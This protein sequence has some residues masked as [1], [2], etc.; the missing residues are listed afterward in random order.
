MRKLYALLATL[1]FSISLYAQVNV[2]ASAG[3]TGPTPY[4]TLKLA[5]D[6]INAGTHQGA[7]TI[8]LSGNTTETASA[9]LNASISPS[10]YS[11]VF[12]SATTPVVISGNITGAVIKLNGADNVTLDGRIGGSGRNITV[13]NTSTSTAT[14]AIWL[15]SVIAGNGA[16]NNI[17]RNLEISAGVDQS[18]SAT[19]TFGIIMSG[20]TISI[21]SNGTDNDN[22]QFVANQIL[23]ARYG[24]LTRGTTTNLNE[25]IIV[26]D[27][28]IGPTAFGSNSI[29]KVGIFMQA[30]AGA[31]VTRNF[32]Q[33]VGGT[34]ATTS[35]GADR[36]GIAIG[37]ENWSNS[38]S[39][40]TSNTYTVTQNIVHDIV[41]ERA[42]SAI[43][44][45]LGTT[46]GG[47][48]TDN[49]VANNFIYNILAN[50]TSGDQAVG[51]GIS[52]GKN[53][54]VVF[55]SIYLSGDLDPG[56]TTSA[57]TSASGIR[58][59]AASSTSFLDLIVKNNNI[60]V[61]LN[62]NNTIQ[63]FTIS[64]NSSTFN[65]GTG[66]LD[67]NNYY[68]PTTNPQ[69]ATGG[70]GN[71]I[72]TTTPWTGF[73]TLT[74]W[75]TAFTPAQDANSIQVVSPFVSATDLHLVAGSSTKL[76]SA[77]IAIA[78]ISTDIDNDTRPGPAGSVNGG[79]TAPDIGADEF[80]GA[81][82][83]AIDLA[84]S[85]LVSPAFNTCET[86]PATVVVRIK[87]EGSST[88]DFST[89]NATVTANVT[90]ATTATVSAILNSGT[91]APGAI[92][93]VPLSPGL[94]MS[95]PG[96]Y[97]FE[98]STTLSGDGNTANNTLNTTSS[99][100][101]PVTLP[102]QVDFTGYTGSNLT[103]VFPNWYEARGANTPVAGTSNWINSSLV[104]GAGTTAKINLAF[105]SDR[106]WIVGP[107]IP[108]IATTILKFDVAI[109]DANLAAADPDG[110]TGTDDSVIVRI[111]TNCGATWTD[112]YVFDDAST[113][114][115]ISNSLVTQTIN[116]SAYAGQ[117]VILAFYATEGTV[118]NLQ[119]YDFHIDNINI[120][121]PTSL[122]VGAI[123]MTTP[124]V[125]PICYGSTE[126]VTITI[127]NYGTSV[128][129]FAA[130]PV[131]V[132]TNVTGAATTSLTGTI[133]AGTLA[134][135]ATT[136]VVMSTTLDMTASGTYTFNAYTN[137][138]GD[139]A[140][141]ND[142]M[143]TV[144]RFNAATVSIP[145][146]VNFTGFTG[147][148][149]A[150]AFPNWREG[151]GSLIPAGTI[152]TWT[153]STVFAAAGTT[154]KILLSSTTDREWI[155]GPKIL[156]ASN[157]NL[158]FKVAITESSSLAVDP[159]GMTG[160]DDS[161]VVRISTDCGI[162]WSNL[163]L[164]TD[165][166]TTGIVSN[167]LV[168]YTIPLGSY[169][170][171]TIMIAFYASE[172]T[173]DDA[174]SYDFHLDDINIYNATA[175]DVGA[176]VLA[177]PL[178]S[179]ACYSSTQSVSVT[180][181]NYGTATI[182]FAINPVTVTT[183]IT[184]AATTMLTGVISSGTLAPDATTN[185]TMS[186]TFDMSAA[187]TYTFNGYTN[188]TGD[189]SVANDTMATAS[190][191]NAPTVTLPQ[192]VDF[193]G[194][195]G[196]NL[197]TFF[198]NWVEGIGVLAPSGTTSTWTS[199]TAF[200]GAGTTARI[201][202]S[203]NSDKEWI[204][205][206]KFVASS[207][208]TLKYKVAIT[209]A[210][211]VSADPVAMAGSDDSVI[212][213]I[214]TD[215]GATWSNLKV[216]DDASTT[217][218][219][220]N[221][222][223]QE[224]ISLGSYA[225]QTLMIAFYASEG[226]VDNTQSYDFHIDDINL[227]NPP[228]LDLGAI[229]LATPMTPTCYSNN[230][231]VTITIKNLGGATVDFAS[232]PVTVTTSVTGA[233][234]TT[235]TGTVNTGTLAAGATL[236][237]GMSATLDMTAVGIYTFNSSTNVS[238][239]GDATNDAMAEATRTVVAVNA[240]TI[241]ALIPSVCV[242]G[243][244]KL[245]VT[246]NAGGS[247][248]WQEST[249]ASGP[250]TNVGIDSI[251]YSPSSAI[252][253]TM[254]YRLIVSCGVNSATS[255]VV[256]VTVQNP[257]VLT[258]TPG[259]RCGTGTVT[260]GATASSGA[261]LNWY[262]NAS[263]G[264]ALGTG[265]SF[266][267]PSISTP[268]DFYVSAATSGGSETAGR[269]SPAGTTSTTGNSYGLVFNVANEPVTIYSV[270]IYSVGSTSGTMS[271]SLT[272]NAGVVIQTVGPFTYGAGSTTNPTIVTLPLN[273]TV[274]VGT[275]YRLI[276]TSMSGG[277]LIR[278][279]SG[280][281]YPYTSP[282]GN[283]SVTSG[284]IT[285]PGSS[286]YY[287]FYNWQVSATCESA[288][289]AVTAT[290][291]PETAI[292]TQ[293]VSQSICT[294]SNVSFTVAAT[295]ANLSY[296]WR[297][298]GVDI[299]GA[300]NSTFTI[301]GV[302]AGD[303]ANY[304]VIVTGT[305]GP[306]TSSAATLTVTNSGIWSGATSTDW[307]TASNWCG[308]VPT[309]TTNVVIP[310]GAANMPL[311]T[312]GTA[313][314]NNITVET[315]ATLTINNSGGSGNLDIYGNLTNSGSFD[316]TTGN[317]VFVGTSIQTTAAFTANNVTINNASG[318]VLDG[319]VTVNGTLI[320]TNGNITLGANNLSLAGTTSGSLASHIIV[321]GTG[322]VVIRNLAAS[323]TVNV[324]IG[325]NSGSYNPIVLSTNAGHVTD[326]LTVRVEQGVHFNGTTG[327][328]YTTGVVDRSWY[329][330]EAIPGGS[331]IN[332]TLQWVA[333]E[334]LIS[335]DRNNSN[336]MYYMG[337]WNTTTG[338]PAVGSNPY[339]Q[340]RSNLTDL[341]ALAVRTELTPTPVKF[342]NFSG[343][344]NG[345]TNILNW[346]TANESFNKGFFI[347]RSLNGIDYTAIDFVISI[348][349]G[350]NSNAALHYSYTDLNISGT[351]QFY[352]LRQVDLDQK[353]R[354]SNI[355]VIR[356]DKPAMTIVAG[357][358]PNPAISYV[359]VMIETPVKDDVTLI[360][361]D[362]NGKIIQKHRAVVET[363]SNNI[364]VNVSHLVSG[365][366]LLKLECTSDC[367]T[368]TVNKFMK[369]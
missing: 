228:P 33:F 214:S 51:I 350:G 137:V 351:K 353:T 206:A 134:P 346:T 18:T 148:N 67:H 257:Q 285:N 337:N 96:T 194:Y 155:V 101:I 301:T 333:A 144:T 358:F 300:T 198:P 265:T 287:W 6:A 224:I 262:A 120:Q 283:V 122:D 268:T 221:S 50:G 260:L 304:D 36:I 231:T 57:T 312:N 242:S 184:G 65:W 329:V 157:T 215:C 322:G 84:V 325:I 24:I 140:A 68:Y 69:M 118:D 40:L 4:T 279:T 34:I 135:D 130:N 321:N 244:P 216:Y 145:E 230:E 339:T 302:V 60:Y 205:S 220:S 87:N 16:T 55:N 100:V 156:A 331:D 282:S 102:E 222:L 278:E 167:T 189:G 142:S 26:S 196:S 238:G 223:Q 113:T 177:T 340:T 149:L 344:R 289:S 116:L 369:L 38:P 204:S 124:V 141:G 249:S 17:I 273:L 5:F 299:T 43:G 341:T 150:T 47:N 1:L 107:K 253:T 336:V 271:V 263:G 218:I 161:V 81:L 72:S 269:T 255:N 195:T 345:N 88:I 335:F 245:K 147:S 295:G 305:C 136:S 243:T 62:S 14:A 174:A 326:D 334:E 98:L 186:T 354:L 250:W 254:Y 166:T 78:G 357:L 19:T 183:N 111:S 90:G 97:N 208:T 288:R 241:S 237:V 109:T 193:T 272:D 338:S 181:K 247:I 294:G 324:P 25:G 292:T 296:Q 94:N 21:S 190:R 276:S 172:G 114:G 131:T 246:G 152:S 176:T 52:G 267:T 146:T 110:M 201:N 61:D 266:I 138:T 89:S 123:G 108:V 349:P 39:T 70:I 239:D 119:S 311:I 256:S 275:G 367:E 92:L 35:G 112:L 85:A 23:K 83:L 286:T 73:L 105:N 126:T 212:V 154:A 318:L 225:G 236:D 264:T 54:K 179:P 48:I 168:E 361:T 356:G 330:I 66:G 368:A 20:T 162:T 366:Y 56:T 8:S 106:E 28:I 232:T 199:S 188:L 284:F 63:H 158:K 192:T 363:G 252:T 258:T 46:G 261:T 310:A 291:N 163:Q 11:S 355:I 226:S 99:I 95:T 153:S 306:L 297:K 293:P 75:K 164:F 125:P 320:L 71:T 313:S 121:N 31:I 151:S 307:F 270:D 160:T 343:R 15:A 308:G 240:G 37:Q 303:A 362:M 129:D 197:T 139:G 41:D 280:N 132:T 328:F 7:I 191:I 30:D 210:S 319:T 80:D 128:I 209:D 202:L 171:Q 298:N 169:D 227:S 229:A 143:T 180:I 281:T 360:I 13:S 327:G 259:N 233:A 314:A 309:S 234:T 187:G 76:E 332:V 175:L 3:T 91:L 217:G 219:I 159:D 45:L 359:N 348:A 82:A 27:N 12:I 117:N 29:G 277:S 347:E 44:I 274:P 9:V 323:T 248:Q 290:V 182:D 235:L 115:V 32:V 10:V 59:G 173:I 185:V 342:V 127:K 93:E 178:V 49:V 213:R 53:D 133:S 365:T 74:D 86:N 316:A 211:S 251:G 352:R 203:F 22:N 200:T 170:G 207:T 64:S 315:G 77:G 103:T 2:T 317:I 58:I 42:F 79:G 364:I 104:T 165:A